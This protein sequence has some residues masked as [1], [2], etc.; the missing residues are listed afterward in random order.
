M[1]SL[2]M[3]VGHHMCSFSIVLG[4]ELSY[5]SQNENDESIRTPEEAP[6][7]CRRDTNNQTLNKGHKM[8]KYKLTSIF[9]V[10]L[11]TS[12]IGLVYSSS[13]KLQNKTKRSVGEMHFYPDSATPPVKFSKLNIRGKSSDLSSMFEKGN[14]RLQKA[15]RP[16]T[17]FEEDD[18]FWE[19]LSFDVT[20]VSEKTLV[21]LRIAINLYSKDVVER[22]A[23]KNRDNE[24]YNKEDVAIMGLDY[25]DPTN[26]NPP[27]TWSLIP[28]ES[29]T[30][31]IDPAMRDYV[32]QQVMQ[33]SSPITRVGIRASLIYLDDG[34]YWNS[35]GYNP[36]T[37]ISSLNTFKSD[38]W[39]P[40]VDIGKF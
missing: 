10:L 31:T 38:R 36:P 28:G 5:R 29:K 21:S 24:A 32:R 25:G 33:F 13:A 14:K 16:E 40:C 9:I 6:P 11:V 15:L 30:I 34:S 37:K 19:H 35:N 2:S 23:D 20:N 39:T 3:M 27:Y 7:F 18:D 22:M 26:L 17:E 4:V 12:L 1:A 8:K